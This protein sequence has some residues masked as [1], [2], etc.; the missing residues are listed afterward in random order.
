MD[1][2]PRLL[3]CSHS[4]KECAVDKYSR[5]SY[6]HSGLDMCP[7]GKPSATLNLQT[8]QCDVTGQTVTVGLVEENR[9]GWWTKE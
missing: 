4:T 3:V 1:S 2:K 8:G 9:A 5:W 6:N 7:C